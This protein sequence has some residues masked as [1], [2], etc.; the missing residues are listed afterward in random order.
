MQVCK[1]FANLYKEKL[2]IWNNMSLVRCR[3]FGKSIQCSVKECLRTFKLQKF[4][5]ATTQSHEVAVAASA[6]LQPGSVTKL[7]FYDA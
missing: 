4:T 2:K 1:M 6:L 5:K 3:V 7:R